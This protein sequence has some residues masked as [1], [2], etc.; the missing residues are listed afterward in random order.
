MKKTIGFSLSLHGIFP[1]QHN[2]ECFL[3]V[4]PCINCH[5]HIL[6]LIL[7][8]K[9]NNNEKETHYSRDIN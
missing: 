7:H 9:N 1:N 4:F 6:L 3:Y 8:P 2:I 5:F